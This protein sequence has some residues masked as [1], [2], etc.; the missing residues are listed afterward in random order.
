ME[1]SSKQ[2]KKE[3]SEKT[4]YRRAPLILTAIVL[5]AIF[6]GAFFFMLYRDHAKIRPI[7]TSN[8]EFVTGGVSFSIDN[9]MVVFDDYI[10]FTGW[11]A[12]D[13]VPIK[14]ND[15]HLVAFDPE[16]GVFYQLPTEVVTREDVGA[17][18]S[19]DDPDAFSDCGF[20][21]VVRK[22]DMDHPYDLYILNRNNG[23][24]LL[25]NTGVTYRPEDIK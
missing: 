25:V 15:I 24:N 20:M 10:R 2:M 13:G 12:E 6:T 14:T 23:A 11:A 3:S 7:D 1:V 17:F 21:S 5:F 22:K 8:M 19:P 9:A 16:T 18:L 4:A